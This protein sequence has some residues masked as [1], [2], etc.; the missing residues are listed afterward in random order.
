MIKKTWNDPKI[1]NLALQDTKTDEI[2]AGKD[3]EEY[4]GADSKCLP[5]WPPCWPPQWPPQCPSQS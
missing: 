1:S 3:T 4:G 5:W 2:Y